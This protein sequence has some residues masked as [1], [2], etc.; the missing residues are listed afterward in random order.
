MRAILAS[1]IVALSTSSLLAEPAMTAEQ[2]VDHFI[3][4]AN[5]GGERA[6]CIGTAEECASKPAMPAELD[7]KVTFE[8]DSDVLTPGA[9]DT[10]REFA[11]A[12]NDPRLGIATFKVEGHTDAR[13]SDDYNVDLSN[14]RA[15]AVTATLVQ[16]GVDP[17]RIEARGFG[18]SKPVTGDPMDPANRRVETRM[19]LPNG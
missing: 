17:A 11:A 4:T 1:A 7:M 9:K 3:A 6:I 18:E 15:D 19:V 2:I 16:L 13:G 8:L 5:I 10:L 14:R 12:F